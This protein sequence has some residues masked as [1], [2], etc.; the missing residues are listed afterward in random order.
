MA[1]VVGLASDGRRQRDGRLYQRRHDVLRRAVSR[2]HSVGWMAPRMGEPA[3]VTMTTR[4]T[5]RNEP[6]VRAIISAAPAVPSR[7][8]SRGAWICSGLSGL[9]LWASFPPLDW[10]PLGWIALVPLFLLIRPFERPRGI[11]LATF[12]CGFVS[13]LMMLQWLRYADPAMY[14]ALIGLAIYE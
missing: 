3:M 9:L 4:E 2:C 13:Q 6:T 1:R 8:R 5:K 10:G 11:L 7:T 14:L 12:V